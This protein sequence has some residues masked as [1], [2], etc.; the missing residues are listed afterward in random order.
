MCVCFHN[1]I[2]VEYIELVWRN[3]VGGRAENVSINE[4]NS[5]R[6]RIIIFSHEIIDRNEE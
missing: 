4:L 5:G 3:R 6:G 2:I 1:R